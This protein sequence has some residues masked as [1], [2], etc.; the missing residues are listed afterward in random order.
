MC[1]KPASIKP[2]MISTLSSVGIILLSNW[3]PSR[4]PTADSLEGKTISVYG[5]FIIRTFN[6]VIIE[7][8]EINIVPLQIDIVE[9]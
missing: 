9:V 3:N 6:L 8:K 2:E 4:G 7:M 5:A 1:L